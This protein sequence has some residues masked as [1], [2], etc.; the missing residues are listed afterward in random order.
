MT[1]RYTAEEREDAREGLYEAATDLLA[2]SDPAPY[3]P[4]LQAAITRYCRA[5]G[6]PL[7]TEPR[8]AVG[9]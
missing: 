6:K 5:F 1:R 4:A 3:L 9:P 8:E 7:P 2:V